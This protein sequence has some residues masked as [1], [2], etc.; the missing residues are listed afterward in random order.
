METLE[1]VRLACYAANTITLLLLA[2]Y[3][4]REYMTKRLRASL[5]WGLGFLLFA[6]VIINL[7]FLVTVEMT[8]TSVYFGFLVT[9][10]MVALLYYGTSLL[11]FREGSFFREKM[12]A[13][14]W[15]VMVLIGW[16]LTY[17][18]KPDPAELAKVGRPSM[19][20][21]VIAY[22]IIGILFYRVSRR[23]PEDDPRKRTIAMVSTAWFILAI[24]NIYIGT[25]LDVY[26]T[27]EAGVLLFGSFGFLLLLY[28]M[29][30]G[31]TTRR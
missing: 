29:T 13:I 31:K 7:A 23:L 18:S 3:F 25:L 6:I 8:K 16:T 4:L 26:P 24:W 22:V 12:T 28:G 2:G 20:M 27:V 10:T 9:A 5:A 14:Y 21:F 1:I 30:T 11:F 19:V 17:L 15:L